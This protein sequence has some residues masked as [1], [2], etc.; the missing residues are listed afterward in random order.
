M[1]KKLRNK[2]VISNSPHSPATTSQTAEYKIVKQD[3]LRVVI[4]NSV[5]LAL[6]LV[7]YY[8]DKQSGYLE[9]LYNNI[10]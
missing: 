6:V 5:I 10:F 8:T 2:T 4:L 3:L 9:R 7:V 1:S